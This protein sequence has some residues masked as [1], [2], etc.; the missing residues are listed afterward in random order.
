MV[1]FV[2]GWARRPSDVLRMQSIAIAIVTCGS[3]GSIFR[4]CWA[5]I[6]PRRELLRE[7]GWARRSS[8]VPMRSWRGTCVVEANT[9]TAELQVNL[10]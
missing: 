8:H 1:G 4:R 7:R 9:N 2:D 5:S 6:A 3:T 10:I